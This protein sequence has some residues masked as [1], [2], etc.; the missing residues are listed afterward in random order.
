MWCRISHVQAGWVSFMRERIL[1]NWCTG[2]LKVSCVCKCKWT[3]PNLNDVW[4]CM[5][6]GEH[7]S[8]FPLYGYGLWG[9]RTIAWASAMVWFFMIYL[10]VLSSAL[11]YNPL[12]SKIYCYYWNLTG[13]IFWFPAVHVSASLLIPSH[14]WFQEST[15]TVWWNQ[16]RI[17]IPTDIESPDVCVFFICMCQHVIAK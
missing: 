3:E 8:E 5:L 10:T 6:L 2:M 1:T 15:G 4:P 9:I 12:D 16:M 17:L 14:K 7:T 13:Q 11:W